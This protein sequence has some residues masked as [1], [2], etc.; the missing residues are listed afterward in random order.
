[1]ISFSCGTDC[2]AFTAIRRCEPLSS[3]FVY[4]AFS[5]RSLLI[6]HLW[7]P[8]ATSLRSA[9]GQRA[10]RVASLPVGQ[11]AVRVASLPDGQRAVRVA[12]LPDGQRAAESVGATWRKPAASRV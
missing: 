3:P 12:S 10:G 11:R 6:T 2:A 4:Q 5:A 8:R 9:V 7:R 1:M